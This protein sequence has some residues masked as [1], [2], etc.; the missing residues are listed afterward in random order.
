[1]AVMNDQLRFL[2]GFELLLVSLSPRLRRMCRW[3]YDRVGPGLAATLVHPVLADLGYRVL[4]PAEWAARAC[5]ALA[6]PG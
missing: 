4:K 1:M 5:L 6:I 3:I 2:K